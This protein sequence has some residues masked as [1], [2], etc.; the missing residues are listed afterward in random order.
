MAKFQRRH[1]Q[2]IADMLSGEVHRANLFERTELDLL[3]DKFSRLFEQDNPRFKPS[4]FRQA[5][6]CDGVD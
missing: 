5:I 6:Y 2:A 1:Y 4:T 3:V